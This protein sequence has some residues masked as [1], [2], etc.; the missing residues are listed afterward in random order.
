MINSFWQHLSILIPNIKALHF[1][2][3]L[4]DKKEK[5]TPR[6]KK[7]FMEKKKNYQP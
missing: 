1:Y 3:I 5:K 6:H 2:S 7:I 4:D